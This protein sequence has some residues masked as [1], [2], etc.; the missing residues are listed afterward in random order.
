MVT[1]LLRTWRCNCHTLYSKRLF[2]G[3]RP[4]SERDYASAI[5]DLNSL[6]SNAETIARL[7]ASGKMNQ[8]AIPEM[9]DWLRKA[10]ISQKM[11]DAP[12]YIHIAGT[13]GKGSTS[14]M[15][16]AILQNYR[17]AHGKVP[18]VG[19]YTSPHLKT[20]RERIQID[21]EPLSQEDWTEYFYDVWDKLNE[22]G[23]ER[24]VYFRYLT[25]LAFKAFYEEC[26]DVVVLECGVGGEHDSTNVIGRP[27]VTGVT[28]LGI[29]HVQVLGETLEQIAWHKAGIFKRS[30]PA[31]TVEQPNAALQVLRDRA[32]ERSVSS[33]EVV[34][35]H[36]ALRDIKLGLEGE[37][38]VHN[39]S[40]AIALANAWLCTQG[41]DENIG[42]RLP[43]EFVS[44]LEG[45]RWPGRCERRTLPSGVELCLDGAHTIESLTQVAAWFTGAGS[46]TITPDVL[47]FNQQTRDAKK[48][49]VALCA[50]LSRDGGRI[51]ASA[52]FC[53]NQ[54]FID[55][56]FSAEL[57][58][59]NTSAESVSSLEVQHDLA[60]SWHEITG[61][62]AQVVSS[63]EEALR[64]A[65]RRALADGVG[66]RVLITG[67]L[68]LVGGALTVLDGDDAS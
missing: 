54:T 2:H 51:P 63:I 5:Q 34:K 6:Q 61:K 23:P 12:D 33:F 31:F 3:S 57:T 21:G 17:L 49:L 53:S 22:H 8:N 43:D 38:Q 1:P 59:I 60:R 30:S 28:S 29:D 55:K 41:V 40:L 52:I 24:P 50:A 26:C 58:S 62:E 11:V 67:S 27:A 44:A 39:A 68:H 7:R 15:V 42:T 20:V 64:C 66:G 65:E 16:A 4:A 18:K 25:M 19:L 47:I 10:G 56:G 46:G 36:P 13:K 32:S 37:F 48:L 35:S 14:A 9:H 45:V